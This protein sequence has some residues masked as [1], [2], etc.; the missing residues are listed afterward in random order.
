ML[1]DISLGE[2][3]KRILEGTKIYT[4]TKSAGVMYGI[5][6]ILFILQAIA[7]F[8][9]PN[10]QIRCMTAGFAGGIVFLLTDVIFKSEKEEVV[11]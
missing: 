8:I 2:F 3:L 4:L 5:M 1:S 9:I 11:I 7:D 6:V 10:D